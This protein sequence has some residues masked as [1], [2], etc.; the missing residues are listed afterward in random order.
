MRILIGEDIL[1]NVLFQKEPEW[2]NSARIW[3]LCETGQI[4]G[5]VSALTLYNICV[6]LRTHMPSERCEAV[7][8]DLRLIFHPADLTDMDLFRAAAVHD[9]EYRSA[10]EEA[11]AVRILADHLITG[12]PYRSH[13]T[14]VSAMTPEAFLSFLQVS[15]DG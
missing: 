7:L 2:Q 14:L 1:R 6:L 13:N 8:N 9:M 11:A 15:H 12:E 5:Y 3:K 10:L 4:C